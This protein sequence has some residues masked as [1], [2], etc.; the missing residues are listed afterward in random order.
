MIN[1]LEKFFLK[2]KKKKKKK[3]CL[4][5]DGPAGDPQWAGQQIMNL[6]KA[7]CFSDSQ[8]KNSQKGTNLRPMNRATT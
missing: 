3:V 1:T 8:P 6:Y 2:G 7:E 4:L 5:V